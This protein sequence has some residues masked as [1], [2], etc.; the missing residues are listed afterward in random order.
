MLQNA[1][2]IYIY[3]H[4]LNLLQPPPP[5]P[6]SLPS[7]SPKTSPHAVHRSIKTTSIPPL[8][9]FLHASQALRT[10]R[11]KDLLTKT[12]P[13]CCPSRDSTTPIARTQRRRAGKCVYGLGAWLM[14]GR[15]Q[16]IG[17]ERRSPRREEERESKE[18]NF[19]SGMVDVTGRIPKLCLYFGEVEDCC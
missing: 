5:Q 12:K 1:K 13:R 16:G 6:V 19:E 2:H 3:I 10:N 11:L 8:H 17:R 7:N 15:R 14:L 18:C 4:P 9:H